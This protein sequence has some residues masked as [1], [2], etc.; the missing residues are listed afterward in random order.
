[1][2]QS[3]EHDLNCIFG[4]IPVMLGECIS[5]L[6][7]KDNEIYVDGTFGG[8]GYTRAILEA[9]NCKV[10]AIDRDPEAYERAVKM[11]EEFAGRLIPLFGCFGDIKELLFS[12]GIKKVNGI[13]LDIGVSSIQLNTAERGFSF[14]RE[15][16]LDMRMSKEG[17][18]AADIV[19][20]MSEKELADIIYKYGE[21]HASR[22][23]AKK[24]IEQRKIASIET[25]L[26]LAEVVHSVIPQNKKTKTDTA[27]KTFQ[28]LRIYINNELQELEDVLNYSEE[29]LET[30]GRLVVVSFHSLEDWRVKNFFKERCGRTSKGSRHMPEI[31]EGK[32]PTFSQIKKGLIKP[33]KEEVAINI[34][35]RS[36]KLRY[37]TR[38]K[39]LPW[40]AGEVNA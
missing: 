26:K 25:T 28:A 12:K 27:T 8:G 11:S 22:R 13:V 33:S 1:M 31:I 24:I 14:Q 21:E 37:A 9:A 7:I 38:T 34:R 39:N 17:K 19:N 35:A 40:I 29:L 18:T 4:H 30:S 32:E 3:L 20:N 36:A 6:D 23:I 5:S 15:G 2:N 16:P 10:Y